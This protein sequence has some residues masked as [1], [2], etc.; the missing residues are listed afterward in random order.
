MSI[1]KVEVVPIVLEA[2][3]NA[4]SLSI[5]RVYGYTV[6]VRTADWRE[7]AMGAYIPPD[8][9]VDT[10]R[11]EFAFL[12]E[13]SRVRVK[14]LRGVVSMGLLVPAPEG[15]QLGDD[16]MERLGVT[17][18]E[19]V[20]QTRSG[21]ATHPPTC[22][23]PTYDMENARRYASAFIDGEP[24]IVTE[25]IHGANGRFVF[26]DGVMHCGSRTEWKLDQPDV[27]WWNALRACPWLEG[28]CR[29]NPGIVV[30]GEVYG[31]VQSLRYGLEGRVSVLVFDLLRGTEWLPA[32][33]AR[34]L[35]LLLSWVPTIAVREWSWPAIAELAEGKSLLLGA[36]HIREGVVVKPLTERHHDTI[37]RVQL[38]VIGNGYLECAS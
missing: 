24:V 16:V 15:A 28:F 26:H 8:S 35:G 25:K 31:R 13:H 19:P 27:L 9:V 20:V 38:K 23:A 21:D 1:H 10:S 32:M 3:P 36:D 18:W 6:C 30:Y 4:D 22:Y 11:P 37:G 34:A 33:E 5:V 14:K 29:A 7:R 17:H 2:H 12:G